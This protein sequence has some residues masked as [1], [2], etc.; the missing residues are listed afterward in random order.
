[1]KIPNFVI[2][3]LGLVEGFHEKSKTFVNVKISWKPVVSLEPG[4]SGFAVQCLATR[5]Y[6]LDKVYEFHFPHFQCEVVKIV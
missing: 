1:M 2:I 5:P 3:P 6:K 4:P